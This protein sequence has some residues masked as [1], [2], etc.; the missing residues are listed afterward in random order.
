MDVKPLNFETGTDERGRKQWRCRELPITI[1]RYGRRRKR[2]F[3]V[4]GYNSRIES[5]PTL[6]AAMT[7]AGQISVGMWPKNVQPSLP[8]G[9]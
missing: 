7:R 3:A 1:T 5:C 4:M 8:L 2:V 9:E 6:A